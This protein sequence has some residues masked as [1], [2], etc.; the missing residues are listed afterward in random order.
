MSEN[1]EFPVGFKIF[2]AP[3][4]FGPPSSRAEQLLL[5]IQ[6]PWCTQMM[7]DFLEK[8]VKKWCQIGSFRLSSSVPVFLY[9]QPSLGLLYHLMGYRCITISSGMNAGLQRHIKA[10]HMYLFIIGWI[11]CSFLIYFFILTQCCSYVKPKTDWKKT[12]STISV[13][14]IVLTVSIYIYIYL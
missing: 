2:W 3:C 6:D 8:P 1:I 7:V 14:D 12:L 4:D 10:L 9:G 11:K 13:F 5:S